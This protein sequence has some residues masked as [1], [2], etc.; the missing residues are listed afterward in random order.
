MTNQRSEELPP[1]RA[2]HPPRTA[3]WRALPATT[4][5]VG[6]I[7]LIILIVAPS[8]TASAQEA[9]DV[10]ATTVTV[11]EE[12]GVCT[13]LGAFCE[14][15]MAWTGNEALSETIAWLVSTPLKILL[16]VV[17]AGIANRWARRMIK[18]IVSGIEDDG[19]P[20]ETT[21]ERTQ[22]IVV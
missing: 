2:E 22:E 7:G 1:V 12:P 21:D 3:W 16:I 20:V 6:L 14:R 13:E 10:E 19:S 15:L 4:L 18:R 17:L 11:S 8:S 5:V 9:S